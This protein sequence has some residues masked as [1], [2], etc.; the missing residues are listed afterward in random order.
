VGLR[1]VAAA[2]SEGYLTQTL[3]HAW[4]FRPRTSTLIVTARSKSALASSY[5]R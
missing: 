1:I 4:V 3:R 2:K 5:L